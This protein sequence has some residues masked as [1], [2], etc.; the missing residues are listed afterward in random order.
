MRHIRVTDRAFTLIEMMVVAFI[1]TIVIGASYALMTSGRIGFN[2]GDTKIELQEDLRD[3]MDEI[4]EDLSDSAPLQA[5]VGV[6]GASITFQ[7]PV[8]QNGTGTWEDLDGDGIA[9]YYLQDTLDATGNIRWG[10]YL[11]REDASVAGTRQGRS[12]VYLLVP[13]ATNNELRRRVITAANVVV[14]DVTLANDI[15]A[16]TFTRTANDVITVAINGNK[17]T[18]DRYPINYNLTTSVFLKNGG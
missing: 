5:T 7:V 3:A 14:E 6:G 11:W 16:L 15:Q 4:V 8:D 1:F 9:D 12:V 10:A 2:T 17:T 13:A 18:A